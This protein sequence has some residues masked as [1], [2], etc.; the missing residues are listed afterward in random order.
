MSSCCFGA[1]CM[2][3]KDNK[4]A[5]V[6]VTCFKN[7]DLRLRLDHEKGMLKI[8]KRPI[9]TSSVRVNLFSYF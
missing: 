7:A 4:M 2:V 1:N 8:N 9:F 3:I 5:K 6:F